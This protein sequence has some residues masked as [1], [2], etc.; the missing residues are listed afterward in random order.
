LSR[1]SSVLLKN[2]V[3]ADDC[4][5]TRPAAA[6]YAVPGTRGVGLLLEL[7]AE[8]AAE[9]KRAGAAQARREAQAQSRR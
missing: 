3:S 1:I 4:G 9:A 6:E 8:I 5:G 2:P 7:P